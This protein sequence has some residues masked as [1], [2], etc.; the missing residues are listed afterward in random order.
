MAKRAR[1]RN[2]SPVNKAPSVELK[3]LKSEFSDAQL[4]HYLNKG[5]IDSLEE[6]DTPPQI[7]WVEDCTIA[8]F[9][10]FSASTGK[11][12]SKKTFNIS[13]MVA[14]ALIN[15]KV[16][17]Y[18]ASL[19][20]GK[21]KILYFD[22]EQSRYHCQNVLNRILKLAGLKKG[23]EVDLL[24]FVE[25]REYTPT[26]RISLIDYALRKSSGYGLVIIDGLRDLV[27]DINNAKESTD[28]MT[29]LMSWTS[30]YCLHIHCVLHQNK[31]DT[32]TRGHIGT[33]LENKAETVLVISKDKENTG[34]SLVSAGQMRDKEFAS[35]AFRID[36][37]A[38]PV[39]EESYH[40]TV[41]KTKD[42]PLT[43][44]PE[45]LHKEVLNELFNTKKPVKYKELIDDLGDFYARKGYKKGINAIK[46]L[47][48]KLSAKDIITHNE[49]GYHYNPEI[50]K[51]DK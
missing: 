21:R 1:T 4:E 45:A 42:V 46:E 51:D 23:E 8:T 26:L 19:P 22:T 24:T 33:E 27:Y 2:N 39:L 18:R 25:L 10:N 14:A 35:F 30:A 20:E 40:V 28:V 11:A 41:V 5:T 29:L 32:N 49:T 3:M 48:K 31:N 36:D 6:I 43:A 12:K 44:L 47:L 37:N 17:D 38:L 13:A 34:I 15:G 9:G 16:L 7:L 50:I